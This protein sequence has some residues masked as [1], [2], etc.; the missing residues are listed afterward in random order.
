MLATAQMVRRMRAALVAG[1]WQR[2]E[3]VLAEAN[4]KVLA[5]IVSKEV[6][7]ALLQRLFIC[8]HLSVSCALQVRAAQDE[9]D[10]RSIILELSQALS[11]G[12]VQVSNGKLFTG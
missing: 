1:D 7:L 2:L 10:N 6:R 11:V 9:L 8:V 3:A 4:G 5:D 12:G